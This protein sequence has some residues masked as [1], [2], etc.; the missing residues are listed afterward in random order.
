MYPYTPAA[1]GPSN[2][3]RA[4][5]AKRP[6]SHVFSAS[7]ANSQGNTS[8][9]RRR[10]S[11]GTPH[12]HIQPPVTP[13]GESSTSAHNEDVVAAY[14]DIGDCDQRCPYCG[15][16]FWYEKQLKGHSNTSRPEYHLLLRRSHIYMS[17]QPDP[18]PYI[19][20]LLKNKYFM[21]HIRPYN[22][23]FAMTS[24]GDKV[25]DSTN[26]GRGPYV[27]KISGEIYHRIGSLCP[28]LLS[29]G[30]TNCIRLICPYS[31]L[32]FLFMANRAIIQS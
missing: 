7:G 13:I 28:T 6:V 30:L 31:S 16:T 22:Q 20:G 8:N 18:L 9:V 5:S 23:M 12:T 3:S 21:E 27:F 4:K 25:D 19:K 29:K 17:P 11:T 15:A 32:S 26:D 24:L 14:D 1:A 2:F 10:L